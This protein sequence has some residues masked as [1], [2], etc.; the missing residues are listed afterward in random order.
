MSANAD[1]QAQAAAAQAPTK[2]EKD[3]APKRR[4]R[5]RA[6]REGKVF[7][8]VTLGVGFAAFNSGNNLL[9]L[10]LG[11]MLSLIVLSG[12]MSEL[13]LM[14]VRVKRRLPSRAHAGQTALIELSMHNDKR[15]VPSYS[16]EVEDQVPGQP[17]ERRCYY[18]KVAAGDTQTAGY[19]RTP[20][21]R[22]YL[23][24]SGIKILTRYPFS[25]FEKWREYRQ[26]ERLLVYPALL[27]DGARSAFLQQPGPD[28]A[29]TRIGRG[30]EVAGLR[31]HREGDEARMIHFRRSA[32]LGRLVV[33]ERHADERGRV[34]IRLD[35]ARPQGAG[36]DWERGFEHA[37]SMAATTAV[38][39]VRGGFSVEVLA[40][41]T[42][43]PVLQGGAPPDPIL[44]FL[45]LLPSVAAEGAP[46]IGVGASR[47]R[48]MDVQVVPR[49]A[50]GEATDPVDS[51][52]GAA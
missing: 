31:A 37:V 29:S 3:E 6:T 10:I 46:P 11:F 27:P 23:E 4:T 45:A 21:S 20:T 22:G 18:L 19:R 34:S 12:I 50:A 15:T 32:A 51:P 7:I 44:R 40:R 48:V 1:Q 26:P 24:L 30:A 47:A 5:L 49:A 14:R 38:A 33:V 28:Q 52:A 17:A 43:S 16:L 42:R 8:M 25:I 39:G 2:G 36:P 9:F 41:G 35:N 13:V